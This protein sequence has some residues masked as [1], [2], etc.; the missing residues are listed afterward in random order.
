MVVI[1]CASDDA[2]ALRDALAA[3]RDDGHE[4]ELV[5]GLD[6]EPKRLVDVI[7]R[8]EGQGL[9]V[10]CRSP[11][12]GRELVEE[13]REILLARHIPFARTLTVAVGGRGALVDRIRSG[14]RR[15]SA[16]VGGPAPRARPQV[17]GLPQA[18]PKRSSRPLVPTNATE[19]EEPTLVGKRDGSLEALGSG[20]LSLDPAPFEPAASPPPSPPEE[21]SHGGFEAEATTTS[22]PPLTAAE[23]SAA[24]DFDS[25]VTDRFDDP[26]ASVSDASI[27]VSA[28]DL[29]DL[30][31]SIKGPIPTGPAV[32]DPLDRTAPGTL[33]ALITGNTV[34]GVKLA[35]LRPKPGG[36]PWPARDGGTKRT[37]PGDP[38]STQPFSRLE[39]EEASLPRLPSTP[40]RPPPPPVP[41]G[42][43]PSMGLGGQPAMAPSMPVAPSE[44]GAEPPP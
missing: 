33:P 25:S 39:A 31:D 30:D 40:P 44:L 20:K 26:S 41:V 29:S 17:P 28:L 14:L 34:V 43:G 10:L 19:D 35:E 3:L 18:V 22:F 23:P 42:G 15:A 32:P 11:N 1:C 9:Y 21:P 37:A 24:T 2:D 7:E 12:L 16:H 4:V 6:A 13:L 8:R 27:P 36:M 38:E 5:N